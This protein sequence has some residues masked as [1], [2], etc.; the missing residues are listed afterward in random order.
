MRVMRDLTLCLVDH[1]GW[2]C[3]DYKE[4]LHDRPSRAKLNVVVRVISR[5]FA[6]VEPED[7]R[8]V[9]NDYVLDHT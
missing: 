4:T 8:M 3:W 6:Q 9:Q 5:L 7:P 2:Q 1:L